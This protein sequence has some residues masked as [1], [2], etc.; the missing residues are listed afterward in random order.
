MFCKRCGI[1]S[2]LVFLAVWALVKLIECFILYPQIVAFGNADT[3]RNF[4]NSVLQSL[5]TTPLFQTLTQ[6]GDGKWFASRL[7]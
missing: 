6:A 3:M 4:A 5:T 1:N 7:R 2:V